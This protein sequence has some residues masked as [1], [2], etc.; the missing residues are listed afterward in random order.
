[1][2]F[3][4]EVFSHPTRGEKKLQIK[5]ALHYKICNRNKKQ[6]NRN[7]KKKVLLLKLII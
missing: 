2:P 7:K 3:L 4:F 6:H 5:K 1:V